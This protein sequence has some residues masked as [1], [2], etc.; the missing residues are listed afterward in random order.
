MSQHDY[1]LDNQDGASFRGD[2][3]SVLEAIASCNS[4]TSEPVTPY[5]YQVWHDT[6]TGIIKQRN[7]ANSGWQNLADVLLAGKTINGLL[8]YTNQLTQAASQATTSGTFKDF[9]GIPIWVKRIT[10]SFQGVSTSGSSSVLVQVG[11]GSPT[12]SGYLGS[13]III[14]TA[15]AAAN[16]SSGFRLFF[17]TSD[18]AT[19]TRHGSITITNVTGN[20]WAVSGVVGLSDSAWATLMGGTISLAGVLDRVRVTT[21]N[22]TDTFDAG[23]VN[24][25]Y[26]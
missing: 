20:V 11:A 3:N 18:A 5:A 10:L 25:L 2:I 9:T 24:I 4:G 6:A 22:G 12:T 14:G 19:T 15:G 8:T 16:F 7:A 1:I 17:N 23:A 21:V 26:E 13:A